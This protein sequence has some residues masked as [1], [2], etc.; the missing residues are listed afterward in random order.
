MD[1][2]NTPRS[3]RAPVAA[4]AI[5]AVTAAIGVASPALAGPPV[6]VAGPLAGSPARVPLALGPAPAPADA[7]PADGPIEGPLVPEV[8]EFEDPIIA[9]IRPVAGGLTSEEV[10]RRSVER[11]PALATKQAEVAAAQAQLDQTVYQF[12]PRV[13]GTAQ[14]VRL[15]R[16]RVNL[17]GGLGDGFL[18]GAANPGPLTTGPCAPDVPFQCVVD[19]TG[20][21]VAAVPLDFDIP[22][23]P[24]NAMS[25]QAQLGVPIS[26]YIARLP[27]A[28]K[29]GQAQV[30]AAQFASTAELLNTQRDARVAYY[31]WT[32]SVASRV[33]LRES[34]IRTQARLEDAEAAFEAGVASRADVMR[35]DAAV[36]TL[37]AASI[38]AENFQIL[39][40]QALSLQMGE[41]EFPRY[42][43]G[44][45]LLIPQA[46]PP[47]TNNLPA[48]IEEA[49]RQRY[50]MKAFA[51]STEQLDYAIKTTRAG[52]Y[53]RLDGFAETTY[54][55]PNQRFFPLE[56]VFRASWSAGLSLSWVMNDA[57]NSVV[58]VKELEANKRGLEA[59]REALRRG[60]ALE[61]AAAYAE[62]ESVRA[63]IEHLDRA[64]ES[65][66][67]GYRVAVD[68]FQ[69]GDATTTDILDAEYERV[70]ATLRGIN[71]KI[72]LRLANLRLEYAT[73]RVEPI[74]TEVE[75]G[76]YRR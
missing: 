39:A 67:E 13:E 35:L 22:D 21:P 17:G 23:P 72:D 15:S 24:L 26:D 16:V 71:A 25:L 5:I 12:I 40:E 55:N 53:P 56:P 60:V 70:E 34:M 65:A 50:E 19:F 61:V 74:K 66:I 37:T 6:A 45:D 51:A 43:I 68:L 52:Y 1:T 10:A 46:A 3:P 38:R 4:L 8:P 75:P 33:A 9:A 14:Y 47:E 28:K 73:G 58:R 48:M 42:Q 59:Q 7:P 27:T 54:A 11:S 20:T 69:V 49:E 44:E 29:A 2:A 31:D 76:S 32:R 18:V 63:E 62:R 30:R 41:T 57:I 64:A 36:A